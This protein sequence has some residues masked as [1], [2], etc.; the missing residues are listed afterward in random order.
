M[1]KGLNKRLARQDWQIVHANTE[2][3]QLAPV[4]YLDDLTADGYLNPDKQPDTFIAPDAHFSPVIQFRWGYKAS[5]EDLQTYGDGIYLNEQNYWGGGP[6]A[7]G[8]TSLPDLWGDGLNDQLFLWLHAQHLNPTNDRMVYACPPRPYYVLAALRLA[9]LIKAI[10]EKQVD[11]PITIVCHSQ[12]NMVGMAA[13]FLGD[14]LGTVTD[15]AGNP[16][17]CVADSYV[18]CN[19]PYSLVK[20]NV[21]EAWSG[22][23]MAAGELHWGRQ[24]LK[25][26]STT[27][28]RFFEIIGKQAAKA[29]EPDKIDEFM[30]NEAHEFTAKADR[31]KHGYG[32]NKT[33]HGRVTLYF[34]P[35]DQVISAS[36]V[37][38][39]GW[40][41]MS[42]EEIDATNVDNVFCQ[43][44]FAER[45]TVGDETKTYHFWNNHHGIGLKPGSQAFWH[46]ESPR[47]KY[48]IK[49]GLDANKNWIAKVATVVTAPIF[50]LVT[51]IIDIRINAL[52]DNSWETPLNAPPLPA[53]FEP[54]SK[55]FGKI[56]DVFDEGTDA[57]GANRDQERV[58]DGDDPYNTEK[59][60]VAEGNKDTEAALR[61]EHHALLRMRARREDLYKDSDESK[62]LYRKSEHVTEEDN[63]SGASADYTAWRT[64]KIKETLAENIKAPATDHSS[65]MTNP[66]HAE[67]AL[68]YD[69][70]VGVSR[71]KSDDM[72]MFRQMADWRYL[73]GLNDNNIASEF[74][75]YFDFGIFKDVA[76]YEWAKQDAQAKIPAGIVNET[77]M[78]G[79]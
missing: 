48:A 19:P 21:V 14:R 56:G 10:R 25:A 12:G 77:N 74:V 2:G 75:E 17:R 5:A 44:V 13:A 18:L 55:R 60:G 79:T 7:N 35:H 66:D 40:R 28:K 31:A 32:P 26:R 73:K 30:K 41:G 78:F 71:I 27:L 51:G 16:G 42:K 68:A 46:P 23:E 9:K 67:K 61:Y 47:A 58:R 33:N 64:K 1:C 29:Q 39:L 72:R 11:V 62:G 54:K 22:T 70:P 3:G 20:K 43:R 52:P 8:C 4:E 63:L 76:V 24:T 49:K 45:F 36:P 65:I 57:P 37:Q 34:N 69:I 59:A 50:Y 15:S 38:G 6:F 53:P